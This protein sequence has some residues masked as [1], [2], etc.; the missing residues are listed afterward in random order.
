VLPEH[1]DRI[2]SGRR[3][4]AAEA[5]VDLDDSALLAQFIEEGFAGWLSRKLKSVRQE[6]GAQRDVQEDGENP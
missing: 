4:L 6:R 3:R 1:G 5:D 2:R